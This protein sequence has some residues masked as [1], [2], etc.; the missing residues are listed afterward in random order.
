MEPYLDDAV[1]FTRG[2]HHGLAFIDGVADG[3][4]DVD[5]RAGFDGVDGRPGHASGRAWRRWRYSGR[6]LRSNLAVIPIA[7]RLVRGQFSLSRRRPCPSG[8]GRGRQVRRRTVAGRKSFAQDV[9]SPPAGAMRAV[10]YFLP[11]CAASRGAAERADWKKMRRFIREYH[12][13]NERRER[14]G[15]SKVKGQKSKV[16]SVSSREVCSVPTGVGGQIGVVAHSI[17][18]SRTL[19]FDL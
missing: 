5:V 1:G 10:L 13:A 3:F 7:A 18:A 8:L 4:F 2:L 12:I 19:T 11:G 9:H 17:C 16:K 14:K 15:K 6:S